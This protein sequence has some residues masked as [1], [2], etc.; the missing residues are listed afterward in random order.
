MRIMEGRKRRFRAAVIGVAVAA[1]GLF[2][3]TGAV[4]ADASFTQTCGTGSAELDIQSLSVTNTA[5]DITY[6]VTMCHAFTSANVSRI[7]WQFSFSD[8]GTTLAAPVDNC[9]TVSPSAYQGSGG[10]LGYL[11]SRCVGNTNGTN[12]SVD[13]SDGALLGTAAVSKSGNSL[14]VVLPIAT[15]RQAGLGGANVYGFR[16]IARD[17]DSAAD[18]NATQPQ[19]AAPETAGTY[20]SH[21]LATSTLTM[22]VLSINNVTKALA[23]GSSKMIFTVKLAPTSART[24]TVHY[25]TNNGTAV[26]PKDYSTTSGTLTFNP[27]NPGDTSH[28]IVVTVHHGKKGV[29][30]FTV[31]L[32]SAVNAGIGQATGTGTIKDS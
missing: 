21:N 18:L 13:A 12:G 29:H 5:T 25:Q 2:A 32:D 14:S 6:G 27:G 26:S 15:L 28:T 31:T 4:A 3:G 10:F 19:D 30:A 16:V 9:L 20:L 24:V 1:A 11:T 17:A 23:S 7:T 22:P 8:D